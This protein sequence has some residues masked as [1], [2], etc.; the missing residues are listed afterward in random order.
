MISS[1]IF[2]AIVSGGCYFLGV[3]GRLFSDKIDIAANGYN[4]IVPAMLSGLPAI[5]TAV[6]VI[7]VFSAYMST[8]SS[9]VLVSGATLTLDFIKGNIIK[10]IDEK[11]QARWMRVLLVVFIAVSVIIVLIQYNSN[12]TFIAQLMGVSRGVLA[13]VFCC[14]LAGLVPVPVVSMVTKTL[15]KIFS[16]Y[17]KQ[18]TVSVKDFIGE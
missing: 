11:E 17:E 6:V 8:F 13:G 1:T 7:M 14:M 4:S 2:A 12:I 5:L 16:C 9:L 10:E 3:S 15:E 18:V